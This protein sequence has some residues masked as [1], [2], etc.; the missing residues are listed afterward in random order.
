MDKQWEDMTADEK[1]DWLKNEIADLV[2]AVER[3]NDTVE[4][5]SKSVRDLKRSR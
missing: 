2:K 3:L 1:T 4:E 5:T